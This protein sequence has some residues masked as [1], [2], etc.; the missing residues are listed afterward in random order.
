MS[1]F[2]LGGVVAYSNTA[3]VKFLAVPAELIEANG[4]V[5]AP[6]AKAMAEGA[7]TAFGA[8]IGVGVTGIAG[9]GGGSPQK[10]VGLVYI[11]VAGAS[12]T[13]LEQCRFKGTRE[14]IKDQSADKALQMILEYLT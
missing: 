14:T 10:P 2:L 11:A 4:A 3:K 1:D 13:V 5:S 7:R 8:D 9:P 6:V 12:D